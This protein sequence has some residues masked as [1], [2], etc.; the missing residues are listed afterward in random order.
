MEGYPTIAAGKI[1]LPINLVHHALSTPT[2]QT[3]APQEITLQGNGKTT[4]D[5][6]V[7]WVTSSLPGPGPCME[8]QSLTVISVG[9][10]N[11][12]ASDLTTDAPSLMCAPISIS[13]TVPTPVVVAQRPPSAAGLPVCQVKQLVWGYGE[14]SP[15][16]LSSTPPRVGLIVGL[17]NDSTTPCMLDGY[18]TLS[19]SDSSGQ[20]VAA[21]IQQATSAAT[22][23]MQPTQE[24]PLASGDTAYFVVDYSTASNPGDACN[25]PGE[26][27]VSPPGSTGS[28]RSS[29]GP[30]TCGVIYVSPMQAQP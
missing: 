8:A 10:A 1:T 22:Y 26:W 30:L 12:V 24:I 2:F 9:T 6:Y 25:S 13:P 17:R 28:L 18:P 21:S 15:A 23:K 14:S 11:L 20:P 3:Q 19:F 4:A 27:S 16:D 5:F 7:D 29:G